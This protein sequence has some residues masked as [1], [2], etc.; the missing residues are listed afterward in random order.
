MP[1]VMTVEQAA[2]YLQVTPET[3]RR[4]ARAGD[5]PAAKVG[6]HWRFRKAD[7]DGWLSRGGSLAEPVVDRYLVDIA[8]ARAAAGEESVPWEQVKAESDL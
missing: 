3:V 1:D 7:L 8:E 4:K 6:R 2:S 5:I